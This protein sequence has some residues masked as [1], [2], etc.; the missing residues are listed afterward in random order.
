LGSAEG[1]QSCADSASRA[2]TFRRTAELTLVAYRPLRFNELGLRDNVAQVLRLRPTAAVRRVGLPGTLPAPLPDVVA[3]NIHV[4][5]NPKR[6]DVKLGQVRGSVLKGWDRE[7]GSR[8]GRKET[9]ART[10]RE[11]GV[12]DRPLLPQPLTPNPYR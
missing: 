10:R 5:F 6:G 1:W 11:R 9:G 4:L 3:G 8:I 7:L 12:S 2:T